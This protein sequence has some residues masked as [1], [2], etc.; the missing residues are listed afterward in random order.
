MKRYCAWLLVAVLCTIWS[1]SSFAAA[2]SPDNALLNKL[3]DKV[4]A[5]Y[6]TA[7]H[8]VL[9]AYHKLP[10]AKVLATKKPE[11]A[12]Y[13]EK[14]ERY[15]HGKLFT[16]NEQPNFVCFSN[17]VQKGDTVEVDYTITEPSGELITTTLASVA[18]EVGFPVDQIERRLVFN[19]WE[20]QVMNGMDQ[21]VLWAPVDKRVA[22][23]V[24]PKHAYGTYMEAKRVTFSGK[25]APELQVAKLH[26][27]VMMQVTVDDTQYML[28]GTV[29]EKTAESATVDF[30]HPRAGETIILSL[31]VMNLFKACWTK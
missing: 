29:V 30:N 4:D 6:A 25:L 2:F 13:L 24:E 15:I 8:R 19:A 23:V 14:I 9:Q 27:R 12:Y 17:Y 11:L 16:F 3:Y 31:Q 22:A 26:E 7:P 10:Y 28:I 18:K 1:L 5:M 20:K 21:L